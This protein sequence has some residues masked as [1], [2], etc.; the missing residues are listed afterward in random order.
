LP[1]RDDAVLGDGSVFVLLG[2]ADS[3]RLVAE[4][5]QWENGV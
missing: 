2:T 1:P 4:L 5:C 3:E